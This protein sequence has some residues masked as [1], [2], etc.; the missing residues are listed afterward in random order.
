[1]SDIY[2][3]WSHEVK[4][5]V[6]FENT[7]IVKEARAAP[8]AP[9]PLAEKREIQNAFDN[10]LS[11][12]GARTVAP[13]DGE[14]NAHYLARLG[15]QAAAYGPPERK[16]I[17]RQGLAKDSPS[18]LAE[19]V[20]EDLAIAKAE[21]ERPHYSLRPGETRMV[22]KIDRS[23]RPVIEFFNAENSPSFWMDQFKSPTIAIVSGGSQGFAQKDL[24]GTYRF[25]K[26]SFIPELVALQEREAYEQTAEYKIKKAYSDAGLPEPNVTELLRSAGK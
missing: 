11:Q 9:N 24:G 4:E 7:A 5:P 17:D 21:I 23:G 22:E 3:N 8:A 6:P 26:S 12:L 20:R 16:D 10:V 13:V 25:D 15:T 19:M 2:H 18:A 14:S 1:M